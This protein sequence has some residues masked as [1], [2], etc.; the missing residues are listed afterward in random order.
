MAAHPKILAI[1]TSGR[2][3]SVAL[4]RGGELKQAAK[5]RVDYNHAVEVLP[6][7][8]RLCRRLGWS[9]GDLEQ[10]YL[11]I[12]PGSFTGLRIAVTLARTLAWSLKADIVAVPTLEVI[13]QNGLLADEPPPHLVVVLDAKRKEVYSAGFAL[14]GQ[15]YVQT[16][17]PCVVDP[18]DFLSGLP[19]PLHILGEGIAYHPEALKQVTHQRLPE[20]LWQPRVQTV[21]QLGLEKSRRGHFEE[22]ARLTPIYLRKPEAEE[23]W[24]KRH[25][26]KAQPEN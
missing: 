18:V 24:E 6:T 12:G 17:D 26:A 2:I 19:Q 10:V 22:P 5:F 23:V 21:H 9:A 14:R 8:D 4:A 25:R 13:A 7:I 11:S 15:Q 16:I 20:A 3:G 1:E